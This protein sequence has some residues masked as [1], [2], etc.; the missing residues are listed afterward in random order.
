M[1]SGWLTSEGHLSLAALVISAMVMFG[2]VPV[3]EAADMT[4]AA[5]RASTKLAA[6]VAEV[7]VLVN[8]FR[9]RTRLKI[10]TVNASPGAGPAPPDPPAESRRRFRRVPDRD[11]EPRT[12]NR[13]PTEQ[14]VFRYERRESVDAPKVAIQTTN[15]TADERGASIS[16]VT[17]SIST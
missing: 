16:P 8:Y 17:D 15:R 5:E 1:K 11:R 2:K 6:A 9:E 12:E 10:E 14:D 3:S 7:L 13:G 4:A